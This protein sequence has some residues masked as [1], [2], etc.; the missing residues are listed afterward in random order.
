MLD[1]RIATFLSLCDYMNYRKTAQHLRMTQP[2]VTQHI[3]YLE[4][5][6]GQKL[7]TYQA[8]VLEKT[9]AGA[10]LEQYSR[11]AYYHDLQLRQTLALPKEKVLRIGATKT[12]GDYILGQTISALVERGDIRVS[13][14]VDNTQNLLRKL[15]QSELDIALIEGFFDKTTYDYQLFRQEHLVGICHKNHPFANQTISMEQL[16]DQ[17]LILREEG[18]GTRAVFEQ[19]L[20][21]HSLNLKIFPK[22][23]CISSFEVTKQL[24]L[25][26]HGVSFVYQSV[27]NSHADLATFKTHITQTPHPFH[28]VYLKNAQVQPLIDLLKMP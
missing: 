21:S 13:L 11:T 24:V 17:L 5:Y 12:I 16:K 4:Q 19:I 15:T 26:G 3:H 28:F 20:Y 14:L 1:Y 10:L 23:S 8:R 27:A 18:S 7:F 9:E 25:S 6:Y 2:A 22:T